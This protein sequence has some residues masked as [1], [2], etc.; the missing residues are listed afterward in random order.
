[1]KNESSP[2]RNDEMIDSNDIGK[3]CGKDTE[4]G[5]IKKNV[6]Q[7]GINSK[8]KEKNKKTESDNSKTKLVKV[9]RKKGTK[10]SLS[11]GMKNES[12][13]K[14]NDDINGKVK[15]GG[16]DTDKNINHLTTQIQIRT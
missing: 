10:K 4:E 13:P 14:R 5:G 2:K 3:A 12:S 1:M 8:N 6:I 15:A 16:K 11:L 7:N 9:E